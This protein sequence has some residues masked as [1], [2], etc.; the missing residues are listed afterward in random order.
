MEELAEG[1]VGG[2]GKSGGAVCVK[3]DGG[4]GEER[5]EAA[6]E[7]GDTDGRSRMTGE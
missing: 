7:S 5:E 1:E 2:E 3:G 4:G 6:V